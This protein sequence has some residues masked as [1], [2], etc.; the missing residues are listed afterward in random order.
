MVSFE[1]VEGFVVVVMVVASLFIVEELWLVLLSLFE[2]FIINIS[3]IKSPIIIAN[4]TPISII[5]FLFSF[6][7]FISINFTL[8]ILILS[9]ILEL[10]VIL[11]LKSY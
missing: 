10:M 1:F 3:P 7:S 9:N 2:L 4:K 8:S 5:N 11:N 6:V